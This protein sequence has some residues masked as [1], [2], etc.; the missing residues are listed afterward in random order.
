MIPEAIQFHKTTS[1]WLGEGG[2]PVPQEQA[3]HRAH[4]CLQ[5]PLNVKKPLWELFAGAAAMLVHRQIELK[6]NLDLHVQDEEELNI[7]TA[8]GCILKL[9]VWQP[10]K[11][12]EQNLTDEHRRNLD[13]F[14]W[15]FE[16]AEDQYYHETK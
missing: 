6:N 8:C 15:I 3:Q 13:R 7:C 1:A 4:V 12:I 2:K 14:C 16:E 10:L 9:K 11:F 5:C